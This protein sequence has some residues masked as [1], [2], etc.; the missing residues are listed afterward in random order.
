MS[1][2]QS[3]EKLT[4]AIEAFTGVLVTQG[5]VGKAAGA[6]AAAAPAPRA[7]GRQAKGAAAPA[8]VPAADE[9][10]DSG[11]G[12]DDG[13]LGADDGGLGSDEA[14]AISGE[15][16]KKVVLAYRDKVVKLK[17][18]DEGLNLTRQLMKKHVAALNDIS[19]ENA[20]EIHKTFTAALSKLK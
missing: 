12:A 6:P 10:L 1:L 16:A 11:L 5:A 3:I 15:E 9:G 19:D 13:G 14:P 18:T 2:E 20:A 4:A 8:P 17:G 7:P